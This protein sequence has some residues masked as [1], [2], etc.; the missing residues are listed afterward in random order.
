[1]ASSL[2]LEQKKTIKRFL[3]PK[4]RKFIE[5]TLSPKDTNMLKRL[6]RHKRLMLNLGFTER[7]YQD[8][9]ILAKDDNKPKLKRLAAWELALF[10]ANKYSIEDAKESL[11]FIDIAIDGVKDDVKL[12][13]AAVL[14]AESLD[15]LGRVNEAR[16]II[17]QA[18]GFGENA[19]LYLAMSNLETDIEN[20]LSWINQALE[21]YHISNISVKPHTNLSIYDSLR[22]SDDSEV[23]QNGEIA[24]DIKVTVIVPVYN[25]EEVIQTALTSI[26]NQTWK[27]LEVLVVD[28]C[29]TDSTT[30]IV[31]EFARRD[32]RVTLIRAEKN[33]GP[34]VAR[35]LALAYATGQ[36]ITCHDA[37]D[38]SH[39]Y[40]IETQVLHLKKHKSIIGNT[41]EQARATDEL[42]LY[43]RGKPGYYIFDNMSSFM[44]RYEPIMDKIGF[45]DSVRFGAD[46]EFIR[47][48][49]KVFGENAVANLKTGPLSFQRQSDNSLT[50]NDAF[51][52]HGYFMGARKEY[53]EAYNY[54]QSNSDN[55]KYD[56]PQVKRPFMIPEPMKP[57]REVSPSQRRHFDV[58]IVSDFRLDGGSNLS[59][60]EEIKAQKAMGL[61]TGLI[62]MSRYDYNAWKKINPKIRE[63]LDE[64]NVQMIVYGEKVSCDLLIVRYPPILQERQSYIPDVEAKQ[65]K[66]I[67]N[68]TPMSDYGPNGV[69]RYNID[70]C[71]QNLTS[72]LNKT[73]TWF[74]IGPLVRETLRKQHS[75][76]LESISLS[77]NDW[78]NI[79]NVDEWKRDKSPISNR[80]ILIGRH[81]RDNKV[82]WPSDRESLLS[83]Y[84]N[85]NRYEIHVL[86]GA[87]SPKAVLGKLPGNWKVFE[88]GEINPK[89]F[90]TSLD[91]FVYYTHPDW[92]ESFGRVIIEAM[93]VGVPVIVPSHFKELFGNAAIYAEPSEVTR[94]VR[95]LMDDPSYYDFQITLAQ[96]FIESNFGYSKHRER[97]MESK[98]VEL[99][100]SL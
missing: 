54:Y 48:I 88:F 72:W 55:L 93:A 59:N 28:D 56:F 3:S 46:S 5:R 51:G 33:G 27:N 90:L 73:A 53:F 25:S 68:Q 37:D 12:R 31:D 95:E 63:T 83:V 77:D 98:G 96:N 70:I 38:W 69:L 40:K 71:N 26:L 45:W 4:H 76:E 62:Q 75:S 13:A 61:R 84:P 49:K 36:F 9:L 47:R 44:F 14:T 32:N 19:D 64:H 17:E 1:M 65:V 50:A 24:Q 23:T 2:T 79:I 60:I 42:K 82:K 92:V 8:L 66:V 52:Y 21:L 97:I 41:S 80:K 57:N 29:S 35:N 15:L 30:M 34:Y 7:G 86:G 6:E 99:E 91:V 81:S 10:H 67:V 85:D 39:P 11:K 100:Y 43:R 89:D 58:I 94:K 16:E 78:V 18:P 20:K 22:V 87:E 74:P